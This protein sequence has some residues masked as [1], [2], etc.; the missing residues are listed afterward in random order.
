ML[1]SERNVLAQCLQEIERGEGTVA[2]CLARY[3]E[4][5]DALA[6]LLDVAVVLRAAPEVTLGGSFRQVARRRLLDRLPSRQPVTFP[7]RLAAR[8]QSSLEPIWI[9]RPAGILVLVS[10]VLA[11]LI[12]GGRVA[13]ASGRALPGDVLYPVKV[14]AEDVRLS[15]ADDEAA[16]HLYLE[17]SGTRVHEMERLA[18][19]ERFEDVPVAANRLERQL[20][21]AA[22]VAQAVGVRDA[23]RSRDLAEELALSAASHRGRLAELLEAVPASVRSVIEQALEAAVE[24][25]EDDLEDDVDV[26]PDEDVDVGDEGD[27]GADNEADLE[28]EA[29][30]HRDMEAGAEDE[31]DDTPDEDTDS[32]NEADGS[33]DDDTDGED[34]ADDVPD[35]DTDSMNEADDGL[36]EDSASMDEADDGPDV[37]ADSGDEADDSPDGDVDSKDETDDSNSRSDDR[38]GN[39]SDD[40]PGSESDGGGEPDDDSEDD[41]G[42][43]DDSRAEDSSGSDNRSEEGAEGDSDEDDEDD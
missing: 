35:E 24:D 28:D 8:W 4:R 21:S 34:E 37:D 23:A 18:T 2:E 6:P 41:S 20:R 33:P 31:P 38:P 36:E 11:V 15:F 43:D 12:G 32:V 22:D 9:K 14:A 7:D 1:K 29:D 3:P 26:S 27:A 42:A 30:D 25:A 19:V 17:F 10:I 40:E 13:S 5:Q 39:G 16:F